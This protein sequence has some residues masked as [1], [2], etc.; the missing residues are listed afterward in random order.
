MPT[1][2][3]TGIVDLASAVPIREVSRVTGVNSVTLRAWERRYGLLK[4][5]RTDKGHRL[6]RPEDVARVE[7]IQGWLARGVAVSQVKALLGASAPDAHL[8]R[9]SDTDP[10]EELARRLRAAVSA[11]QS[12]ALDQLLAEVGS[13]YPTDILVDKLLEPQLQAL[14]VPLQQQRADYGAATQLAFLESHLRAYFASALY[15]FQPVSH[16]NKEPRILLVDVGREPDSVLPVILAYSLAVNSIRVD[17]FGP[18][19]QAEWVFAVEQLGSEALILYSDG[20]PTRQLEQQREDF[21]KR[22]RVPVWLAGRVTALCS[23]GSYSHC[24]GQ[25][26]RDILRALN[27]TDIR[28]RADDPLF[29]G[30]GVSE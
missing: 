16:P 3:D 22:L 15:R 28:K 29:P 5:L 13:L 8:E 7:E 21:E 25:T 12:R 4:P 24:L 19:P 1:S 10:W 18:V 23:T 14:R 17:F 2:T 9:L 27:T 26:H 11:L 20:A 30:S 6:Y